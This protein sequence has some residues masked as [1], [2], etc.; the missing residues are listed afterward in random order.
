MS[1]DGCFQVIAE[2]SHDFKRRIGIDESESKPKD[3]GKKRMISDEKMV[4]ACYEVIDH[5]QNPFISQDKLIALSS[6]TVVDDDIVDEIINAEA[7]GK[8]SLKKFIDYRIINGTTEFQEKIEK[9]QLKTFD[10]IGK[11]KVYKVQDELIPVKADRDTFGRML[12]IQ[13][14]R[15]I[16]LQDVLEYELSSQP[17]S[18]S[19]PNGEMQKSDKSRLFGHLAKS[20]TVIEDR[21]LDVPSIYDGM[22]LLQKL[23]PH[24]TTFDAIS[25]YLFSKVISGTSTAN[26]FV[27]DCYR[28]DSIKSL[29]RLRRS[30]IG[31]IRVQALRR[32]QKKPVQFKKFLQNS[33]NKT[34]LIK[35]IAKDWSTN[36]ENL[37]KL[38]GKLRIC[39]TIVSL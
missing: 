28:D 19:K 39:F 25:D 32:D 21:P 27:S 18:L 24:L 3:A 37:E 14:I 33:K 29:E 38:D 7:I 26:F 22:V 6:G 8:T 2:W 34:D 36:E 9:K 1:R 23:P 35:F 10:S 5:W 12:V 31:T 30:K 13:R 11:K 16:D 4:T 15:G 17:L 20:L